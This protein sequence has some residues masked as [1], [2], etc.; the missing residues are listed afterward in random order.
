MS[1]TNSELSQ[2]CA[3]AGF[4]TAASLLVAGNAGAADPELVAQDTQDSMSQ[5]CPFTPPS[6][7]GDSQP[8]KCRRGKGRFTW[9]DGVGEGCQEEVASDL[10]GGL[11]CVDCREEAGAE[12]QSSNCKFGA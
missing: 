11:K 3:E 9:P 8:C 10:T 7:G 2:A 5:S 1:V 12:A 6:G 4:G